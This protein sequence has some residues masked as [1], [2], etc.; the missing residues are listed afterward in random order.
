MNIKLKKEGVKY[1]ILFIDSGKNWAIK[2]NLKKWN[3]KNKSENGLV[4]Y[5]P[6]INQVI[7]T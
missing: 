3:K 4:S 1:P 6:L 5:K 2:N 7:N